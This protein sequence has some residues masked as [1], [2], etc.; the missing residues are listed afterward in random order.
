MGAWLFATGCATHD[1]AV[2][3]VIAHAWM[4]FIRLLELG[5]RRVGVCQAVGCLRHRTRGRRGG[6]IGNRLNA[7]NAARVSRTWNSPLLVLPRLRCC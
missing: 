5:L 6:S 2:N 7:R 4:A 3:A 1:E